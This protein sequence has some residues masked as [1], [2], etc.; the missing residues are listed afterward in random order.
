MICIVIIT[1]TFSVHICYITPVCP[2][3]VYVSEYLL[4]YP[5]QVCGVFLTSFR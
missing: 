2:F 5:L 3:I 4:I 1:T